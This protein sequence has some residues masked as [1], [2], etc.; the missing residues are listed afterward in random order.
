MGWMLTTG[1][2]K[3]EPNTVQEA[4]SSPQQ[5][6]WKAAMDR[7][8]SNLQIKETWQEI[9]APQDQAKIGARRV[10]KFIKQMW[11]EHI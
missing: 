3:D 2:D 11:K 8:L 10:L 6:Q 7:E 1:F 5:Q 4:L 9:K